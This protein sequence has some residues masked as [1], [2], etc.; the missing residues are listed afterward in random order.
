MLAVQTL[1]AFLAVASTARGA[2]LVK[3]IAQVIADSTAKWE[4]ACLSAGGALQC[5]PL[6][7]AAFST[8]LAAAGPCDQQNAADNM[9][10][11]AHQLSSDASMVA[12]TQ[13]FAQ[14]PRN[15]PTSLAVPYCQQ[16]PRNAELAG[17]FQCQF[18]G[19]NNAEFVGNIPVGGAGTIPFGMSAPLSPA[20]SCPANPAGG[21]ADGTQLTDITSNP[22]VGSAGSGSA[23]SSSDSQPQSTDA[24]SST[25]S[26]SSQATP[27]DTSAPSPSPTS[28]APAASSSSSSSFALQ[29]GQAAQ[30]LNAQFA[31]LSASS[32]CSAGAVAC[33]GG[34]FAQ[35]VGGAYVTSPCNTAAGLTCAALPLVNSPGTSVTCT[36]PADATARI[37][38]TGATGGLTGSD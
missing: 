9:I 21:I 30:A 23:D 26:D 14:Q 37:A 6:S 20:G 2:P 31:G 32:S 11:L 25:A 38:A 8:L 34:A 28:D 7:V 29:N 18:Q 19:V 16:A 24:P 5:N 35:C 1:F 10:D 3:R 17:L 27:S 22:G 12:F 15:S 13:L 4:Q 33:V 36:T